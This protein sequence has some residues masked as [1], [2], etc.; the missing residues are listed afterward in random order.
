[1]SKYIYPQYRQLLIIA[2][3]Q[4][5]FSFFVLSM[6]K[7]F[8]EVNLIVIENLIELFDNSWSNI[9]VQL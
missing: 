8:T 5:P 4:F 1:M 2:R 9:E 7:V 6:A 3:R